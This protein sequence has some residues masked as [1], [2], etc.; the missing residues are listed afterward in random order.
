VAAADVVVTKPGYG[1]VSECAAND[2]PLL[3][4]SRGR[5]VEYEVFV[6]QMPRILRCRYIS[7]EDLLAGRWADA[8]D[9]LLAQPAP[10]ERARIDGAGIAAAEILRMSTW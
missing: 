9:A 3:Y 4:T 2:T 7:Q 8:V 1:I 10:R 6:A 5:F